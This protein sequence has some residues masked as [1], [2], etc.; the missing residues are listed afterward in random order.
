MPSKKKVEEA[1]EQEAVQAPEVP[2]EQEP[3]NEPETPVA[4][5][6]SGPISVGGKAERMKAFLDSQPKVRV[7]V[8]L[9]D[10]EKPGVTQSVILNGYS[11][12]IRKGEYVDV[13][14][15]V[16]EV[17]EVKN[18]HKMEVQNHPLRQDGTGQVKLDVY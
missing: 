4:Q 7:F 13:A 12:Y 18:K 16:A 14:Q 1:V 2:A 3:V 9:A 5:A 6:T 11:V 8:P 17:L 10:G 15:P